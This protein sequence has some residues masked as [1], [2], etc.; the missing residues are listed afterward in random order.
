MV[1]NRHILN[2]LNLAVTRLSA[3]NGWTQ[4]TNIRKNKD[5]SFSFCARGSTLSSERKD[6]ETFYKVCNLL[7]EENERFIDWWNDQKGRKRSEVLAFVRS[8]RDK[9]K[10]KVG[11]K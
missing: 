7:Q 3:K 10:K 2:R 8:V 1:T 6:D 4:H 9:F 11:I 5:G